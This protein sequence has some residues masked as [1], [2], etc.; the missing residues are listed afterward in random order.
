MHNA[1]F[2]G[3]PYSGTRGRSYI[4]KHMVGRAALESRCDCPQ[5]SMDFDSLRGAPPRRTAWMTTQPKQKD[6][7]KIT[8]SLRG[9]IAPVA[10]RI[11]PVPPGPGGALH[12]RGYGLPR[13][14]APRN[15]RGGRG[16][17]P[18]RRWCGSYPNSY[19]GTVITVHSVKNSRPFGQGFPCVEKYP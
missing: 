9:G 3:R 5:Q 13:R 11:F 15:D 10:I 7:P 19:C 2:P 14:F 4:P 18:L 6:Q 12:R 16:P 17:V 1:E 8:T